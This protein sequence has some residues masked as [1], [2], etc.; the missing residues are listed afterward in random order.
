MTA[1]QWKW[2][3]RKDSKVNNFSEMSREKEKELDD[4]IA[5]M[6]KEVLDLDRKL[7]HERE[8]LADIELFIAGGALEPMKAASYR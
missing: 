6:E 4:K 5:K 8:K 7:R 2:P 1:D 3:T